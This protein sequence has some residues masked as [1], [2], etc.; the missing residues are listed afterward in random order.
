MHDQLTDGRFFRLLHV[1]DDFNRQG[2]GIEADFSLPAARVI[3]ALEQIILWHGKPERIRCDN[4]PE[5]ISAQLHSWAKEQKID[6]IHIQAGKL[7]QNA[8]DE[9]YNRTARYAWHCQCLV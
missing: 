8:Y 2:L 1:L 6:A 9:R 3:S 4:G 5:Y 7:Q